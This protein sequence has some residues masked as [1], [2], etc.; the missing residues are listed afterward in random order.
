MTTVAPYPLTWP[1]GVPRTPAAKRIR[2]PFRTGFDQAI[3]N[4]AKSLRMFQCDAGDLFDA[5]TRGLAMGL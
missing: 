5:V 3:K 2:S 4:V 1:T